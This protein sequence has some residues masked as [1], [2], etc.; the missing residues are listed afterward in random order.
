MRWCSSRATA[1]ATVKLSLSELEREYRSALQRYLLQGKEDA[2]QRGY[3]LGREA[4]TLGKGVLDMIAL[5]ERASADLIFPPSTSA[6]LTASFKRSN[7]FFVEVMSPFEMAHRAFGEANAALHHLNEAMENEAKRIAHSLHDESGQ[8][9]A[10][11]HIKLDEIARE[12][13]NKLRERIQEV[14]QVLDRIEIDL[15]RISHELRPTV[16]DDFGLPPAVEFLSDGIMRRTGLQISV[17]TDSITRLPIAIET[18]IY[19]IIQEALN[20]VAKHSRAKRVFIRLSLQPHL[21]CCFVRDDGVGFDPN[22]ISPKAEGR[23]LGLLGIRERLNAVGG[24]VQINSAPGR[25]TE[26]EISVPLEV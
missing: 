6:D 15:R 23:G 13:P 7:Q 24:S 25:G 12:L 17:E 21:V 22:A 16:L 4:M 14:R 20:N 11:I 2:L 19:R 18:A 9:L 1:M 3:E 5:H 26:L 10:A 8:L